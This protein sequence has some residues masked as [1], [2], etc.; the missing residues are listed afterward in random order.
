MEDKQIMALF[1]ERSEA[2]ISETT[3][4]YGR[5]CHYIAYQILQ[6]DADA[7]EVVNDVGLKLW[8]TIPPNMPKALKAYA[9][10]LTRQLALDRF[11]RQ[12]A[13]KRG[14]GEI[15]LVLDELSECI[16][17][18][19]GGSDIGEDMALRDALNRFVRSLPKK[20]GKM[21]V[22]RY[23]YG[24]SLAEIAKEYGMKENHV[25]VLLFNA[26]KKLKEYLSREGFEV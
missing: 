2:A 15:V 11:E 25:G 20:T 22:R 19:N 16:P 23:W 6:N 18:G 14:G 21:F 5:Y 9:G 26:R 1:W 13:Q 24:S 8:N 7:E 17:E 12:W 10:M 3:K 4:K